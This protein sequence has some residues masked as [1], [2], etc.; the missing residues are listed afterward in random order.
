MPEVA[1]STTVASP[2]PTPAED[3]APIALA[4]PAEPRELSPS[5]AQTQGAQKV[6]EAQETQE[7]LGASVAKDPEPRTVWD[8]LRG[9]TTK[10]YARYRIE[11]VDDDAFSEEAIASTLRSKVLYRTGTYEDLYGVVETEAVV[12]LGNDSFNSTTNGET[13]FPVVPDPKS[14]E[15][16]QLF[17]GYKGIDD[18]E[19][20]L[21]RQRINLDNQRFIGSVSWRQ[22]E[23]TFDGVSVDYS[24]GKSR[25]FYSWFANANRI[26]SDESP[27]GDAVMSSHVLNVSHAFP[28]AKV[29]GY[30]Y[31]L[32]V[33]ELIGLSTSTAGVRVNG[34][35][36]FDEGPKLLYG[37]EY[38]HQTDIGDNPGDV[39]Q[40]Y[41]FGKLGV[42]NDKLS[43]DVSLEVLGGNGNVGEAFQTPFA[44]LHAF[45]GW[46]DKFLSTPPD[47]LEDLSM[48][49][50]GNLA[51]GKWAVIFHEFSSD[52]GNADYGSELDLLFTWKLS[53]VL[54]A[55]VKFADYH[56][57]DFSTDSQR[58]WIWIQALL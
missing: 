1:L 4:A 17:L 15:I 18:V 50:R 34:S 36:A 8:A 41:L 24:A 40:D 11:T 9:G 6:A 37:A 7:A 35:Y 45:N 21:G 47:G 22:N 53:D 12:P 16:N 46:A 2:Q 19:L 58:G 57:E 3:L 14:T 13:E 44:T 23:Q 42:A 33:D 56:A 29:A 20:R 43:L 31:Y 25:V 32:D 10:L 30:W 55:G 54:S 28:H 49:L 26:F 5:T 52:N 39:D 48:A 38:A 51:K 27:V